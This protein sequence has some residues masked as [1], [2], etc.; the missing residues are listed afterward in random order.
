MLAPEEQLG[1]ADTFAQLAGIGQ[2]SS[3]P[4][5]RGQGF[6]RTRRE[7]RAPLDVQPLEIGPSGFCE[8]DVGLLPVAKGP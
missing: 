8:R 7:V 2:G 1:E 4:V 6:A 3:E 5:E